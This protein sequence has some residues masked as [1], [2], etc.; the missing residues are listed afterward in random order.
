VLKYLL[1]L[2]KWLF[3]LTQETERNKSDIKEL[4]AEL[5]GRPRGFSPTDTSCP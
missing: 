1:D 5:K 4:R 3:G 2:A